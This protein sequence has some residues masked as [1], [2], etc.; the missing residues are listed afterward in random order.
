M[1]FIFLLYYILKINRTMKRRQFIS[2]AMAAAGGAIVLPVIVPSSVLGKNPP[3][4]KIN[5]GQIGFGRIAMTHDLAET[6]R[7]DVARIVAVSDYDSKR[8]A[9]GKQFIE[10][11]YARQTGKQGYVNVKTYGDYRD[12]IA[13][14]SIDAV[15]IST[16]DHWHSQ[17]AMEAA[18]AGKHIY[19]FCH[20][21]LHGCRSVA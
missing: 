10:N 13:D 7:Y 8:L 6:L 5:I 1:K 12:I 15:I 11:H 3:G 16:P 4:D 9:E 20:A 17:P 21:F 14:K 19:S 2:D 18:I